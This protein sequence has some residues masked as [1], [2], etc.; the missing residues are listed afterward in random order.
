MANLSQIDMSDAEELGTGFKAIPPGEYQVYIESSEFKTTKKGNGEYLECVL[1]VATGE[2]ENSK[3]FVR[4]NLI[5][6][7]A[8]AVRIAKSQ[9]RALCEATVGQPF[10]NDSSMLH[11]RVFMAFIDNVPMNKDDPN[12]KRSNEVK[13]SKGNVYA[14][15]SG[16]RQPA[17][18]PVQQPVQH[19]A[20]PT[21]P[22]PQPAQVAPSNLQQQVQAQIPP[23][24]V[25]KPGA[26]KPPWK[27]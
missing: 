11:N 19:V 18:Q 4:L 20:P 8:D 3:V 25:V 7:N 10:V 23:A 17:P 16:V 21:A 27:K 5:N 14:L 6:E 13:F 2:Y 24:Q 22:P 1:V 12:S 15:N 26:G 9:L